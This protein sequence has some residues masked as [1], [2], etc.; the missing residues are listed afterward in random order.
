VCAEK[1]HIHIESS[2][3]HSTECEIRFDHVSSLAGVN[4]YVN[5]AYDSKRRYG[6]SYNAYNVLLYWYTYTQG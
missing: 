1:V 6:V 5:Y 3:D 2:R 4:P